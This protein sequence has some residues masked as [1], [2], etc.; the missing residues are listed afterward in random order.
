MANNVQ[1]AARIVQKTAGL[2]YTTARR[3]VADTLARV[4][5]DKRYE[6]ASGTRPERIA[7]VTLD[8]A[9]WGDL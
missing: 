8:V 3:A 6:K 5:F 4:D 2:R 1:K 9:P 7:W